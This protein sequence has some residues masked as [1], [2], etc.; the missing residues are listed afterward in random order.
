MVLEHEVADR[1]DHWRG[2]RGAPTPR[3]GVSELRQN[4]TGTER[5]DCCLSRT[6]P[7]F[8]PSLFTLCDGL[9]AQQIPYVRLCLP[10]FGVSPFRVFVIMSCFKLLARKWRPTFFSPP[11]AKK[12]G[13]HKN[14]KY[15]DLC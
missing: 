1:A 6:V 8:V 5:R 11:A 2:D 15:N 4:N 13:G 7:A 12:V 14:S 10:L 9:K 3:A